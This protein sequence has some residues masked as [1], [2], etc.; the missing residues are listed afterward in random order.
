MASNISRKG[1]FLAP[2][3]K[4][5]VEGQTKASL[6]QSIRHESEIQRYS[7]RREFH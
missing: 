5:L 7:A 2:A 4:V 1:S 6:D 3:N